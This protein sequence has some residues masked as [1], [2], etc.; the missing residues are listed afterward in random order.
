M[1]ECALKAAVWEQ[2][3]QQL[4][5]RWE[6]AAKVR[7]EQHIQKKEAALAKKE[8]TLQS[9]RVQAANREAKR[10]EKLGRRQRLPRA[11]K[12]GSLP[13]K[14]VNLAVPNGSPCREI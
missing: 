1:Q 7:L 12:V 10:A 13:Q 6:A 5:E 9:K 8:A 4:L 11:K 2:K 3:Q 14:A